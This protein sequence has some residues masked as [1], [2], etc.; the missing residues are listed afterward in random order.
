MRFLYRLFLQNKEEQS[1]QCRVRV[2]LNCKFKGEISK[3][4]KPRLENK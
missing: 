1:G 3:I 2:S 4:N